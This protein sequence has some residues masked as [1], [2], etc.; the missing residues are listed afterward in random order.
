[1]GDV[2]VMI[3]IMIEGEKLVSPSVLVGTTCAC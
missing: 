3:E 2:M 1:M